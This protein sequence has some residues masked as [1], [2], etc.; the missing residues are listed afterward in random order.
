MD[1]RH[2]LMASEVAMLLGCS[3]QYVGRM[4]EQGLLSSHKLRESGW[5]RISVKS[6]RAYAGRRHI[7]LDFSLLR[8]PIEPEDNTS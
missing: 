7:V 1:K 8:R 6:L 2:Y 5:H 4:V 3:K